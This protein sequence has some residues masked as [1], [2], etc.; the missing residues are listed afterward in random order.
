MSLLVLI[1]LDGV[2]VASERYLI[3]EQANLPYW[4]R[5][6]GVSDDGIAAGVFY[7]PVKDLKRVNPEFNFHAFFD[8]N[9]PAWVPLLV[10]G[11]EVSESPILPPTL[12]ELWNADGAQAVIYFV[13]NGKQLEH[14][15]ND[16]GGKYYSTFTIKDLMTYKPLFGRAW[17]YH[18]TLQPG[19]MIEVVA[20]G[21]LEDGR[22]FFVYAGNKTI[23]WIGK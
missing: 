21:V 19:L 3:P 23:V 9:I 4:Q 6:L 13:R 22:F 2:A 7:R 8:F 12:V 10:E 11:Y 17:F 14:D 1:L 18:E 5:A 20:I 15:F 16:P